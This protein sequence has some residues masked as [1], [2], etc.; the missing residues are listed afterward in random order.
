MTTPQEKSLRLV[1]TIVPAGPAVAI[2]LTPQQVASLSEADLVVYEKSF[3]PAVDE[4]VAQVH[5]VARR[6]D[7]WS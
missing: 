4:A 3:Q 1:T 6:S 5:A 2:R 7:T